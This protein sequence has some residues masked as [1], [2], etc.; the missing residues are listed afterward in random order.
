MTGLLSR[1]LRGPSAANQIAAQ[2]FNRLVTQ[3]RQPVFFRD[4][5]V[6]DSVDGR[7]DMLALHVFLVFQRLKGQGPRGADLAQALYDTAIQDMEASLRQLG[8]GDAGVGKRIRVMT[9]ALQGRFVA[10]ETALAGNQMDVEGAVRR[11]LYG[12]VEPNLE[13]VRVVARYLR[14]AKELADRQPVDRVLRGYFEFPPPPL[15]PSDTTTQNY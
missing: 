8:A 13:A 1:L 5:G 11:N 10:Y 3:A 15:F 2:L 7:F 14:Q 4:L 12:T 9:E 6:P